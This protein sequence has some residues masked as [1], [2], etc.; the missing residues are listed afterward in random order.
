MLLFENCAKTGNITFTHQIFGDFDT[1]NKAFN[2][3]IE[4]P[5]PYDDFERALR[6]RF[7]QVRTTVYLDRN[8][9]FDALL[10]IY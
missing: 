6:K 1:T 10:F 9:Y 3:K 7:P 4:N 2:V 5:I 8:N